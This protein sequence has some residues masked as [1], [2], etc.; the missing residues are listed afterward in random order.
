MVIIIK[1]TAFDNSHS[2]Y[3]NRKLYIYQRGS[4]LVEVVGQ[5]KREIKSNEPN[6]CTSYERIK[7]TKF[8][9]QSLT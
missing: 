8:I 3:F 9:I 4:Q 5:T 2:D 7:L 6:K 1:S